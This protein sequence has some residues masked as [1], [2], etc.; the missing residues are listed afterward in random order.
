ML[1][2]FKV[3]VNSKRNQAREFKVGSIKSI[4]TQFQRIC[5]DQ[6]FSVTKILLN[7]IA[8]SM[9]V[10]PGKN[11]MSCTLYVKSFELKAVFSAPFHVSMLRVKTIT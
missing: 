4:R 2:K 3:Q 6:D 1:F 9:S 5:R 11:N 8:H 7:Y 10:I